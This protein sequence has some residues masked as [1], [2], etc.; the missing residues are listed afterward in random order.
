MVAAIETEGLTKRYG[1]GADAV[2]AVDDLDLTVPEGSVFGFLGRNGAGKSTTIDMLLD[3]ATPTAG[4]ATVFGHDAT[5]ESR[6]IRERTGVLPEGFD[7]YRRLT[8]REHLDWVIDTR[9]TDDDPDRLLDLVDL[10]DA[11][12]RKAGGYS[13]GMQQRL[14]LAMALAGDPDLLLLD[15][16]SS[17]LDPTAMQELRETLRE[18]AASGTT[19]FFSSHVLGEVEAVCDRVAIL[20]EGRLVAQDTIEAL[21]DEADV[22]PTVTLSVADPVDTDDLA[23]LD[24]IAQATTDGDRVTVVCTDPS[25]KVDAVRVVAERTT[26][27]DLTSTATSLETLFN[28][29]TGDEVGETDRSAPTTPRGADG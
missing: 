6:Q 21:R 4:S 7:V 11:A 20:R 27:T 10:V 18:R 28:R 25:R 19:I 26:V 22:A 8:G 2:V 1:S 5:T 9:G 16:P 15:E 13:K 23:D 14:G 24:G 3:F 17:G 12:D 29:Y